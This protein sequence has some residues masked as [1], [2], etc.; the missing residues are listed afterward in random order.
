MLPLRPSRRLPP[1]ANSG[2][3]DKTYDAIQQNV[4]RGRPAKSLPHVTLHASLRRWS[5]YGCRLLYNWWLELL[6]CVFLLVTFSSLVTVLRQ[7]QD[8]PL[9]KWPLGFSINAALSVF[10][11]VFRGPLLL[12]ASEGLSQL[13][14]Q[15]FSDRRPLSDMAIFDQGSRGP[16]GSAK[17]LRLARWR[18]VTSSLGALIIVFAMGVDPFTQSIVSYYGCNINES[19]AIASISRI[20]MNSPLGL[21]T[22]ESY[23]FS[24]TVRGAFD[25]SFSDSTSLMPN[26]TCSTKSC[27][28][29]QPYHSIGLCSKCDNITDQ[30]QTS[31]EP[32]A[33]GACNYT[34]SGAPTSTGYNRTGNDMT[35][36]FTQSR[37]NVI[38][39]STQQDTQAESIFKIN[40]ASALPVIACRC[41][42]YGCIRTLTGVI[43]SGV[44]HETLQSTSSNWS[45]DRGTGPLSTV[46]VDCL[47]P[48]VR[49]RLLSDGY[50]SISTEWM[51]WNATYLSGTESEE[52]ISESPSPAIPVPC[53]YQTQW[54]QRVGN[55]VSHFINDSMTGVIPGIGD[56]TRLT[57]AA[58][59][60]PKQLLELYNNGNVSADS[61]SSAFNNFTT[62]IS[63]YFRTLTYT[64][65]EHYVEFQPDHNHTDPS[66]EWNQAVSGA[67]SRPSTCIRVRW[68]WLALPASLVLFTLI[69]LG[70]LIIQTGAAAE[71]GGERLWKSSQEALI[72][73]GLSGPAEGDS[74]DLVTASSMQKRAAEVRVR[75]AKTVGQGWK[76]VQEYEGSSKGETEMENPGSAENTGAAERRREPQKQEGQ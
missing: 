74:V 52:R 38:S 21:D 30:L 45:L 58:G 12:I 55:Y 17:L 71:K 62:V 14:W 31:C 35:V 54:W 65:T 48:N 26:Y 70:A 29:S 2:R 60:R 59:A 46:R 24:A 66:N 9:P 28:F 4:A 51:A 16:W 43:D 34:L 63:N 36:G 40:L 11:A 5:R 23:A 7:Y 75:F 8:R 25:A 27:T 3:E 18:N 69:F 37:W 49:S 33:H 61:I 76:L 53:I 57:V 13:K 19:D 10:G 67:A 44:L 68:A 72:W 39:A 20:N 22:L 56:R 47:S 1:A 41:T 15:W 32:G 64:T 73:H 6:A 42:V 50:I